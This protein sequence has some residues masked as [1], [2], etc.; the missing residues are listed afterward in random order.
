MN[1]SKSQKNRMWTMLVLLVFAFSATSCSE[2]DNPDSVNITVDDAAEFVA[3]SIAARTYGAVDNLNYVTEEVLDM[4]SCGESETNDETIIDTSDDR[5]ISVSYDLSE[6]YSKTCEGTETVNYSFTADQELTSV[7]FDLD[8][9]I[10]GSWTIEGVQEG[11]TEITYN[12]PYDRSGLWTFNLQEDHTDNV[13][14]NSTFTELTFDPNTKRITGG[15][16]TFTLDG[17]STVYDPFSYSGDVEFLGSDVSIITF[18]SGEQYELNLE[19]GK[20]EL[21]Q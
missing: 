20:I 17:T 14:Y 2:D 3:Y 10:S 18:S 1:F 4:I 9:D 8:H 16:A 11:A 15:T 6:T 7:R 13:S 12:G 21:V 19:T 5:E